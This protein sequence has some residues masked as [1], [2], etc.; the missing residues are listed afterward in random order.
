[1]LLGNDEGAIARQQT[2]CQ[3]VSDA[4]KWFTG[5]KQETQWNFDPLHNGNCSSRDME[6]V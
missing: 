2:W 3:S 4:S 6:Y 1:M 5:G